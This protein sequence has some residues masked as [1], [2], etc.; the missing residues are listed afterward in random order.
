MPY[1]D[2][3]VGKGKR[4]DELPEK[5]QRR[6]SRLEWIRKAKVELEAEAAEQADGAPQPWCPQAFK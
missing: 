6:S 5:L 3:Q 4:G 1:E 2:G